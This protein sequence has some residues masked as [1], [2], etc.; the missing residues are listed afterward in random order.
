[1][2]GQ[3]THYTRYSSARKGETG[4]KGSFV[5][6][7]ASLTFPSSFKTWTS[8]DKTELQNQTDIIFSFEFIIYFFSP[9]L[10]LDPID[11]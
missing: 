2:T 1:M 9:C 4:L 5:D 10:F 6:T 8:K 7:A 11:F 3:S